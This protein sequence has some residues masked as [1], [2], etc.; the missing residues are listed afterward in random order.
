MFR[1]H[2]CFSLLRKHGIR[3]M[4]QPRYIIHIVKNNTD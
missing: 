2:R 4:L 1:L 3:Y